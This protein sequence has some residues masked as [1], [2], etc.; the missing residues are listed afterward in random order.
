MGVDPRSSSLRRRP[1]SSTAPWTASSSTSSGTSTRATP[2]I[3]YEATYAIFNGCR[4]L[5]T[6]ETGSPV[7]SKRSAGE[8][9]LANLPPRW[10]DAIHAA[11]R[12]YDG[13]ATAE[14]NETAARA[15]AP[16]VDMVQTAP[17][18]EAASIRTATLVLN[19][20]WGPATT[21]ESASVLQIRELASSEVDRVGAVL[22]LARLGQGDGYYLVA[23]ED[24]E[25][26]GH[27]HLALTDPPELQDVSVRPEYR[28][29]GV[30]TALAGAAER[31]VV[32]R[33]ADRL[34]LSVSVDNDAALALYR[35]LGYGDVGIPPRRVHGTVQIRTGPIEVDDTL[36]TWEKSLTGMPLT[37]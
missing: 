11:G 35:G 20:E 8:W 33:G 12:W 32:A 34:R 30:A 27:A 19:A 26:V 36:L 2:P 21:E 7:I 37:D 3:P 18:G 4:I 1:R 13:V 6:L 29:R 25:P 23:W 28:R 24:D 5:R 9:G 31:A 15:M 22:G 14:D 10:H 16:F 17:A